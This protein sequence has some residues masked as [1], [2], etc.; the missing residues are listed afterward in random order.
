MEIGWISAIMNGDGKDP[1]EDEA[2]ILLPAGN[3]KIEAYLCR[4]QD[5]VVYDL[6]DNE[7]GYPSILEQHGCTVFDIISQD[8]TLGGAQY[9]SVYG[10]SSMIAKY[11]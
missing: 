6:Q 9:V 11:A 10:L 7:G 2:V 8:C 3:E 5:A 4:H 1:L